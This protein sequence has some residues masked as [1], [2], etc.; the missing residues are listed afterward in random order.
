MQ[1][2]RPG[3]SR[4]CVYAGGHSK[5]LYDWLDAVL[6]IFLGHGS[7]RWEKQQYVS[8]KWKYQTLQRSYLVPDRVLF[9]NKTD[10]K[11]PA[12]FVKIEKTP[13][14]G[15]GRGRTAYG[16]LLELMRAKNV[17]LGLLTNGRQ[18]RLCY[19]GLDHDSWVEWDAESWFAEE[20]WRQQF[21][22]F[23]T[24]L[25]VAGMGSGEPTDTSF[26][27]LEAAEASRSCQGELSAV[28]GEQVRETVELLFRELN[29]ARRRNQT[30]W[31]LCVLIHEGVCS[32]SA[33]CLKHSIRQRCVSLCAW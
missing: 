20:E 16:E 4:K 26:P 23:Y 13:R 3:R 6:E 8:S 24:L 27:L 22:G 29:K 15:L 21:Y 10:H 12:L 2:L 14:I 11:E 7:M 1:P 33:V 28:L 31:I 19:V 5:P 30:C 9:R 32:Q 18:F 25:G 17:K